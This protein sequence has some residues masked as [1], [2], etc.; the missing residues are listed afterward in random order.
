MSSTA[1]AL[2][3]CQ[4]RIVY[5]NADNSSS[6]SCVT[7][8]VDVSQ[9]RHNPVQGALWVVDVTGLADRFGRFFVLEDA[10][11]VDPDF[12][13]DVLEHQVVRVAAWTFLGVGP[14]SHTRLRRVVAATD[15]LPSLTHALADALLKCL[16]GIFGCHRCSL[17]I[18]LGAT[19]PLR[20]RASSARAQ[21][22]RR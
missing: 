6:R 22:S 13:I 14:A 1:L 16:L 8:M 15:E 19:A 11:L 9:D 20:H 4:N 7:D 17:T 18:T 21:T 3:T 10:L 2:R 5:R 12:A